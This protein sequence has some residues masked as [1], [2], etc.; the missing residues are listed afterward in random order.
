VSLLDRIRK[1]V[2][3]MAEAPPGVTRY[4]RPLVGAAAADDPRFEDL[5]RLVGPDH[6]LPEE[7]LPGATSVVA[8]F[9]P[10]TAELVRANARDPRAV[11]REWAVAY[12]ETN[13]LI[14]AINDRIIG[15]LTAGGFRAA[16]APPT[17]VFD[18]ATLKSTW[19][20][21]SAA[22]IAGLGSFGVHHMLI[23]DAGCAG[24]LGSLVTD[25]QLE[26]TTEPPRERCL[27][28]ANGSCL[29]CV[30]RCPEGALSVDT[31]FDRARCWARC[32]K[33]AEGFR[34][35]GLAEVCGKCATGPCALRAATGDRR[36][37]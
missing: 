22:A 28:H 29:V 31:R 24:R 12:V 13:T 33:A 20:H 25:A 16:A 35:I 23:T 17:G 5:K 26:V 36:H 11:A 27:Y 34:D 8:F 4:R 1:T 37:A 15:E 30:K 21:K 2:F 18:R 14:A 7:L 19:S 10:F 6:M 3:E 9:L 32:Q